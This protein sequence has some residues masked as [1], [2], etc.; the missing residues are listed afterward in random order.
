MSFGFMAN[1]ATVAGI[2]TFY[3][4]TKPIK[5]SASTAVDGN[6]RVMP[7]ACHISQFD[8]KMSVTAGTPRC[9]QVLFTWD[10]GGDDPMLREAEHEYGYDQLT[11]SGLNAIF[12]IHTIVR[13]PGTQSA[14]GEVYAWVKVDGGTVTVDRARLHWATKGA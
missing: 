2:A 11:G 9:V 5:L 10:S 12:P 8:L 7:Q 3:D 14:L 6:A 13:A 1:E 4:I